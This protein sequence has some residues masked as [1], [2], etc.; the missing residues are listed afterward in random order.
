MFSQKTLFILGAG[1]SHSYGYPLGAK[2][3]QDIIRNM[4]DMVYIPGVLINTKGVPKYWKP[5]KKCAY[6]CK[7]ADIDQETLFAKSVNK[8]ETCNETFNKKSEEQYNLRKPAPILAK[9]QYYK[10]SINNIKE[11]QELKNILLEHNPVSIDAFLRDNPSHATAGKTMIMY[12]ILKT[13]SKDKFSLNNPHTKP[14]MHC[15]IDNCKEQNECCKNKSK[16]DAWYNLLL[17]DLLTGCADKP[18]KIL[19][20][21]VSFLTFNYDISLNYY[22]HT[23]INK[24]ETLQKK[25]IVDNKE[26]MISRAFLSNLN[27]KHVYG[28]VLAKR[29]IVDD[30]GCFSPA[31]GMTE[32]NKY[33]GGIFIQDD[34]DV[35]ENLKRF[36][37]ALRFNDE[38]HVMYDKRLRNNENPIVAEAKE[39]ITE[40]N[41]L[42][43]IGFGFD[44][45]NLEYI[46]FPQTKHAIKQMKCQTLKYL[47]YANSM[48]TLNNELKAF[49][50]IKTEH[51]RDLS[52]TG[53]R[54]I[55]I[56]C[57]GTTSISNAYTNDFKKHILAIY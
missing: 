38:I 25:T 44:P 54:Y 52:Q 14:V 24:I 13:E 4:D 47:N 51:L 20:N 30:Y 3:I 11:F 43:F 12:S 55:K 50:E 19:Q 45:D 37:H 48:Q 27:I 49:G 26:I 57:S 36:N 8:I 21:E 28:S 7:L 22:L 33:S 18:E 17:N 46:G 9:E 31:Q 15:L 1:S 35:F 10:L 53:S 56:V 42:I 6:Y 41:E 32:Y 23:M 5:T 39:S 2:F 16:S 40:S 34:F 29:K